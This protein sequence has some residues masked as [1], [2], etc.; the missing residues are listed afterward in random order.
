MCPNTTNL[1]YLFLYILNV[2]YPK[3]LLNYTIKLNEKLI[4]INNLIKKI[5]KLFY[6]IFILVYGKIN[7]Q[8][9]TPLFIFRCS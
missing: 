1:F 7:Y 6:E 2:I 5:I 4:I 8:P 3:V 9:Q